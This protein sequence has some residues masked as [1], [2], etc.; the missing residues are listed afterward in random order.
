MMNG[1]GSSTGARLGG[2]AGGATPAG[3]IGR[4]GVARDPTA[5]PT[6]AAGRLAAE[7]PPIDTDRV[8]ALRAAIRAGSYKPDPAAIADRMIASD[9]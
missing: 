3:A 2:V 8:A 5:L 7:G 4:A 1:I 9:L 6:T